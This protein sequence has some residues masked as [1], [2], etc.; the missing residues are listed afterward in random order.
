MTSVSWN[1]LRL[2]DAA[3]HRILKLLRLFDAGMRKV[4]PL[5]RLFD[6]GIHK[7]VK[8]L[9][10]FGVDI[11]KIV[12][13]ADETVTHKAAQGLSNETGLRQMGPTVLILSQSRATGVRGL[14]TPANQGVE[15]LPTLWLTGVLRL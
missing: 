3:M 1:S 2:V 4:L 10:L 11:H 7:I 8:L 5:L 6:V 9:R 12:V 14:N 15:S 13:R